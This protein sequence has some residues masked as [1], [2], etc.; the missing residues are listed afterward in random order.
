MRFVF[1]LIQE[2]DYL[3]QTF[4]IMLRIPLRCRKLCVIK[5]KFL[6]NIGEID[7]ESIDNLEAGLNSFREVVA[8]IS[9]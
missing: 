2:F 5:S 7:G 1:L 9:Q 6:H 3:P 8:G 4:W